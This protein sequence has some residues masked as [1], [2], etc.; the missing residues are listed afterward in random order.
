MPTLE[1]KT[2]PGSKPYLTVLVDKGETFPDNDR[3]LPYSTW[4]GV[5]RADGTIN[6]WTPCAPVFKGYRAAAEAW[7]KRLAADPTTR[8][9]F[10]RS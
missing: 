4:I 2:I 3:S 7:L 8:A 6:T 5:I 1:L 10:A 9:H